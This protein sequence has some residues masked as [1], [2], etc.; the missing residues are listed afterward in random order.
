MKQFTLLICPVT[1][2]VRCQKRSKNK[3]GKFIEEYLFSRENIDLIIL[4]LDIRHKPTENDKIMYEYIKST[5]KPYLI[6]AN[7]ADKIAVTKVNDR[8]LELKEEL[9][10]EEDEIILPFSAERRMY[11]EE[12]WK[13]IGF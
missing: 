6:I 4:I 7:K 13:H 10:L 3:F 9:G 5:N 12:V 2:I 1:G 8:V 11:S